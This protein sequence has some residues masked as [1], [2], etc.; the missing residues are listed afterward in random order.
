MP[1]P[2]RPPVPPLL[3]P[4]LQYLTPPPPLSVPTHVPPSLPVSFLPDSLP[5]SVC[6]PVCIPVCCPC[7]VAPSAYLLRWP[8]SPQP[9]PMPASLPA[10]PA[11]LGFRLRAP[12]VPPKL[13]NIFTI[14]TFSEGWCSSGPLNP[15]TPTPCVTFRRIVVP[16]RSLDSHPFFPSHAASLLSVGR[17]GRCSCW[18]RFRVRGAQ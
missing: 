16:L 15:P 5:P 7:L 13:L 12:V 8:P 10:S 14:G 6:L 3:A 4:L 17:C 2:L 18:C 11:C 9:T 1:L